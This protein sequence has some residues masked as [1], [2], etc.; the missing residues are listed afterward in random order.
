[1][2]YRER[3]IFFIRNYRKIVSLSRRICRNVA[4]SF[5]INDRDDL[6]GYALEG[7]LLGLRYV[8]DSTAHW[9]PYL[10]KHIRSNAIKGAM[11][12]RGIKRDRSKNR[13]STPEERSSN[14]RMYHECICQ[15]HQDRHDDRPFRYKGFD[16]VM[17][18]AD[19]KRLL[20]LL[21]PSLECEILRLLLDGFDFSQIRRKLRL[22]Y[23][24]FHKVMQ[25]LVQYAEAVNNPHAIEETGLPKL[26]PLRPKDKKERSRYRPKTSYSHNDHQDNGHT[27]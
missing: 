17:F 26:H 27:P 19:S 5:F 18:Q 12:M 25:N 11:E 10:S 4:W 6:M 15:E 14:L 9:E 1:M 8:D 16:Q 2:L 13:P 3:N 23:Y 7:A 22:T 21:T 24:T 20:D